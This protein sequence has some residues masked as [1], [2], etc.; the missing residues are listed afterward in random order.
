[1]KLSRDR[2]AP[3]AK[4][5]NHARHSLHDKNEEDGSDFDILDIESEIIRNL[6]AS[7]NNKKMISSNV[8]NHSNIGVSNNSK[9]TQNKCLNE[10]ELTTNSTAASTSTLS[11]YFLDAT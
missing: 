11:L 3:V 4:N 10:T 5:N 2:S 7:A 8:Q 6:N 9:T 1:M